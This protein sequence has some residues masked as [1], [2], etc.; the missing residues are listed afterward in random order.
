MLCCGSIVKIY[1]PTGSSVAA[2]IS[3]DASPIPNQ[4]ANRKEG[5]RLGNAGPS[6]LASVLQLRSEK[7]GWKCFLGMFGL[8]LQLPVRGPFLQV[9]SIRRCQ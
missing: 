2:S 4:L 9:L 1:R 3:R 8:R 7:T 6:F 5:S